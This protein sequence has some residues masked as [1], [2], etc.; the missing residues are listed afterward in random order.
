MAYQMMESTE[1]V[2]VSDDDDEANISE[3]NFTSDKPR[4]SSR[5]FDFGYRQ[6]DVHKW[7]SAF[8]AKGAIPKTLLISTC[9]MVAE[10][11][12]IPLLTRREMR[13]ALARSEWLEKYGSQV[14]QVLSRN[15]EMQHGIIMMMVHGTK[16][17][18]HIRRA[19]SE[20][21]AKAPNLSDLRQIVVP[22]VGSA[23]ERNVTPAV[24]DV[25]ITKARLVSPNANLQLETG[26]PDY[27][28]NPEISISPLSACGLDLW[29]SLSHPR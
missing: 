26:Q 13:S 8:L 27:N 3:P 16:Y 29:L 5:Q 7:L 12:D 15:T 21:R 4:S 22:R 10:Y 6:S 17:R 11:L 19:D 28:G 24:P 18:P 14:V 23:P 20:P 9:N 2:T 25:Q 1:I